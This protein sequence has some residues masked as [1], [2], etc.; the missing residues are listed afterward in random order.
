MISLQK[1]A[2]GEIVLVPG[3]GEWVVESV[4]T[5]DNWLSEGSDDYTAETTLTVRH[6]HSGAA[7]LTFPAFTQR[8]ACVARGDG[9][10]SL[11]KV[12]RG[13]RGT[14]VAGGTV[15]T[16]R[17]AYTSNGRTMLAVTAPSLVFPRVLNG[18]A[19]AA[20]SFRPL[21]SLR[22][23][24]SLVKPSWCVLGAVDVPGWPPIALTHA[25]M[26][27]AVAQQ[28]IRPLSRSVAVGRYGT[29]FLAVRV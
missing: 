26:R 19:L 29:R 17:G 16:V 21:V 20:A 18:G 28:F 22:K 24:V 25:D 15:W 23:R 7:W 1:Y 9:P 5:L 13:T 4:A 2:I 3:T 14:V 27:F 6:R 8:A 11:R 10:V 12:A